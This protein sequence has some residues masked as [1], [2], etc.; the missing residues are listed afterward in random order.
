MMDGVS[1]NQQ[2]SVNRIVYNQ[3][4]LNSAVEYQKPESNLCRDLA[5]RCGSCKP[6]KFVTRT[7]PV[8]DWLVHY[9]WKRNL[10]ADIITGLTIAIMHIPQGMAYAMLGNVPPVVG[11]YMG[12]FPVFIYFIFG[13]SKHV[14]MGTFAIVCLMTGKVVNNYATPSHGSLFS[15]ST[16]MELDPQPLYT[17]IEVGSTVC[18]MTGVIYLVM[19]VFRL[20]I[21]STLLSE[22]LVNGFITGAA[23]QVVASQMK[24][25]FGIK[26]PASNGMFTVVHT[27]VHLVTGITTINTTATIISLITVIVLIINNELLKPW[28]SK[29]SIIPIPI[30][31][32]AVV[33]G[34]TA[35]VYGHLP[36]KY[37]IAVVGEI[38]TGF[39]VPE[40]PRMDLV[41]SI[42]FDSFTIAIVGYTISLSMAL[43]FAQQLTYEVDA[44]QELLAMGLGNVFG[45]FFSCLPFSASLSRS[46]IQKN[47]GGKTQLASV[48]S[49]MILVVVLLWIAPFFEAL[50]KCI[51]ASIIL[52]ALKSMLMQA[53]ELVRFWKLSKF[54]ASIWIITFVSC[55]VLDID[56]GL[57]IG[58]IISLT[59]IFIQGIKPYTCLLGAVTDTDLYLDINRYKGTAEIPGV[60]IFHYSGQLNFASRAYFK[61]ELY[62]QINLNPQNELLRRKKM[63]KLKEKLNYTTATITG[64]ENNNLEKKQKAIQIPVAKLY[65]L[66]IDFSALS[67]IDPSGVATVVGICEEFNKI[68]VP[69]L[70][71]GCS[72]PVYEKFVKCTTFDKKECSLLK[73]FPTV[74]DA[75]QSIKPLGKLLMQDNESDTN[76][77]NL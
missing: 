48:F 62:R 60:K 44:N 32:I 11:L 54:D 26:I 55:V 33:V 24:D 67:Y 66:I 51:L 73:V 14:S 71:S 36:E 30:E 61:S 69:V 21:I 18:L 52:V 7:I 2:F 74:H 13:T 38:P 20:G 75:V 47:V 6:G 37:G 23:V 59:V 65:Y 76:I 58:V 43:I 63:D 12:L 35:S 39:P 22:T 64:L 8:L 1:L 17:P 40:L 56:V 49:C 77:I 3:E 5:T 27:F 29:R 15:N 28:V 10:A 25:F 68:G 70:I 41:S 53:T 34:T 4:L 31:L 57:L 9:N 16:V 45:S 50:P 19:Y 72:G 42:M 46:T